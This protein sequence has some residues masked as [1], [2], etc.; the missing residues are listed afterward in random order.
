MKTKFI[1]YSLV[2]LLFS[3]QKISDKT[4]VQISKEE[5]ITKTKIL[6]GENNNTASRDTSNEFIDY[7]TT[8]YYDMY[9]DATTYQFYYTKIYNNGVESGGLISLLLQDRRVFHYF[10]KPH[11]N[12]DGSYTNHF[13]SYDNIELGTVTVNSG[14]ITNTTMVQGSS[15]EGS[16]TQLERS[17]WSCTRDCVSDSHI[18]CFQDAQ[19]QTLLMVT[20]AGAGFA[21]PRGVGAGSFSISVACGA[22]C[23][24]NSNLDLLPQY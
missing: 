13:T 17:W 2:M 4:D 8:T 11:H 12:L 20:N 7:S 18:A 19:C 10:V 22:A 1:L 21:Q 9:K 16:R 5:F 14:I 3:C 6:L 24:G 23:I 15:N